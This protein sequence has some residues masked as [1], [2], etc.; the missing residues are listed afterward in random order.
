MTKK[1]FNVAGPCQPDIHYMVD[2]LP[3]LTG[4]KELID[5][6]EY[7]ILHA[8]RQTGKTTYL[9]ALMHQLNNEGHTP[10]NLVVK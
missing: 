1:F 7:F 2:P 3:R 9:Y 10:S 6:R 4:V 5:R 8:P